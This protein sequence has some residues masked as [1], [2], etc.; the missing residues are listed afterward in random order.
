MYILPHSAFCSCNSGMSAIGPGDYF[1]SGCSG[2][3]GSGETPPNNISSSD[4]I[5]SSAPSSLMPP[6]SPSPAMS[7]TRQTTA[8]LTRSLSFSLEISSSPSAPVS[9]DEE[10]P[11]SSRMFSLSVGIGVICGLVVFVILLLT[12]VIITGVCTCRTYHSAR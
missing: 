8:T 6:T 7:S 1:T 11:T 3:S 9:E 12:L 10:T 5:E 4:F 2:E